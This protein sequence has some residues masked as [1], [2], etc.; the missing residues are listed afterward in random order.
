MFRAYGIYC[1]SPTITYDT[2]FV[3]DQLIYVS[4]EQKAGTVYT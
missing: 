4:M 3:S 2:T 1:V